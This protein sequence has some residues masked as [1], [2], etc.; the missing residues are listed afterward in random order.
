MIKER[1]KYKILLFSLLLLTL[2]LGFL[3]ISIGRVKIS[4]SEVVSVIL[5]NDKKSL[6]YNVIVN[7]RLCRVLVSMDHRGLFSN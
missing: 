1:D 3:L 2:I 7:L 4:F 6:S 5:M